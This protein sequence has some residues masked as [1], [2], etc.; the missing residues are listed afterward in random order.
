[1]VCLQA[2]TLKSE[3]VEFSLPFFKVPTHHCACQWQFGLF[4]VT[5][6]VPTVPDILRGQLQKL[7]GKLIAPFV[8]RQL[9][10]L[11]FSQALNGQQLVTWL[12]TRS[13]SDQI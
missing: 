11:A 8:R 9:L 1:M 2:R 7:I 12:R 5:Q 6:L 13:K 4:I 10:Q 3:R